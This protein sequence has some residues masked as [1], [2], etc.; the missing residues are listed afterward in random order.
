MPDET[1]PRWDEEV[2]EST[3]Y[4]S[5]RIH[6]YD[7][8]NFRAGMYAGTE[9]EIAHTYEEIAPGVTRLT[10]DAHVTKGSAGQ[11]LLLFLS[12]LETHRIFRHNLE[13]IG[14]MVEQGDAYVRRYPYETHSPADP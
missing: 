3:P 8:A 2:V 4:R 13:N 6:V 12:N 9:E 14:L 11:R 1:G 7:A 5:R 10:F